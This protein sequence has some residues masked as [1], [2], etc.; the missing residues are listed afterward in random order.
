[1][2][3]ERREVEDRQPAEAS[4]NSEIRCFNGANARRSL[5]EEK[6]ASGPPSSYNKLF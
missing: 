3:E 5:G 1:M 2:E 4:H 6:A